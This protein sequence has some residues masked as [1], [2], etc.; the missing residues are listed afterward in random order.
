MYRG[1]EDFDIKRHKG[2]VIKAQ[3]WSID[4]ST[5]IHTL[6]WDLSLQLLKKYRILTERFEGQ[7]KTAA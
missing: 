7:T 5:G 3:A 4:A 2:K 1:F 6:A